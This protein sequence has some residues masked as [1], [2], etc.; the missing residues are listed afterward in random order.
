M[1]KMSCGCSGADKHTRAERRVKGK[2]SRLFPEQRYQKTF[3][4]QMGRR[5]EISHDVF[6]Q[7]L[8]LLLP[9]WLTGES[10]DVCELGMKDSRLR[11][12]A[13]TEL[14]ALWGRCCLSNDY[15]HRNLRLAVLNTALNLHLVLNFLPLIEWGEE[16]GE[17]F[18]NIMGHRAQQCGAWSKTPFSVSKADLYLL[19]H[20]LS[21]LVKTRD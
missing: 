2:L 13:D 3:G 14:T 9:S 16:T 17:G 15:Y 1:N 7:K 6:L 20:L 11:R 8:E 10:V 5:D 19:S 12:R 4:Q 21:F 18:P